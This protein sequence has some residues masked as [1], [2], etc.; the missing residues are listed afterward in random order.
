MRNREVVEFLLYPKVFLSIAIPYK[1]QYFLRIRVYEKKIMNGK[2]VHGYPKH[3][4]TSYFK[5]TK[6]NQPCKVAIS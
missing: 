1:G 6:N 4:Q 2:V 3:G 5:V